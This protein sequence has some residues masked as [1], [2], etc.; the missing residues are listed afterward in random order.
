MRPHFFENAIIVTLSAPWQPKATIRYTL[1]GSEPEA[2]SRAYPAPLRFDDTTHLRVAA[3]E[4]NQRVCI[5]SEGYFVRLPRLPPAPDVHLSDLRPLRAVGPG[6]SPSSDSHRFSPVSNPPQ[7][8]LNNRRGPLRLHGK[9][10]T[11]GMGVHA[12]NQLV[13]VR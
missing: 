7:K 12:P 4:G 1:D 8:D 2:T 6:H 9:T 3:F 10:Y 13:H 11:K 5:A